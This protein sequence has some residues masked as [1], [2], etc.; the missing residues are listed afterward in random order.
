MAKK[1][2]INPHEIKR[3]VFSAI[4]HEGIRREKM[5]RNIIRYLAGNYKPK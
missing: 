5:A 4:R 1:L 3:M 2:R